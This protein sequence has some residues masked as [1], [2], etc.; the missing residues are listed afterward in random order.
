MNQNVK[1]REEV[2]SSIWKNQSFNK[3]ITT[4]DGS[5]VEIYNIGVEN[6]EYGGPDFSNAKIRIGNLVFVGDVEL[7]TSVTDWKAHGHNLD[8]KYNRVILQISLFNKEHIPNVYSKDGRRIPTVCLSEFI[9]KSALEELIIQINTKTTG[10]ANKIKCSNYLQSTDIN[11]QSEFVKKLG[12]ERLRKKCDRMFFRLK[13]LAFV[14]ELNLK[15]PVI[16]Y[17]LNQSF[18]SRVFSYQDFQEIELWQQLFYESLFEA[19]GYSKNKK[20]MIHLTQAVNINVIK[21]YS[22]REDLLDV[23]NTLLIKVAG[24]LND[25]YTKL[26]DSDQ[27]YLNKLE[28]KWNEIKNDYDGRMFDNSLWNFAKL[29]PQNFPTIRVAGGTVLIHKIIKE[30]FIELLLNK[31]T[32]IH[33][34]ETLINVLRSAFIVKADGYWKNHYTVGESSNTS[35]KFFVGGMRADDIIVNVVIPFFS[36]YFEVFGKQDLAKKILVV[37]STIIQR[38]DN[39]IVKNISE[40]LNMRDSWKKSIYSQGML[41]LFRNYCSRDKCLECEIGKKAF[42]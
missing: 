23:I 32:A 10:S 11:L 31:I 13:E 35:L 15:E 16:R 7:D 42:N 8:K 14:R 29:R 39:S 36:V 28:E 30:N 21:K 34:P 33:K 1:V 25:G 3:N 26:D 20:I 17:D 24:F 41:E 18:I 27:D 12:V 19:L 5:Q 37:Y 2:L 38:E 22:E 40:M 4:I 6:V 9:G